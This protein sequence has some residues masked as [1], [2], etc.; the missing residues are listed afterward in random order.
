MKHLHFILKSLHLHYQF[1]NHF[2]I[3][4][5]GLS[6]QHLFY[7]ILI[8]ASISSYLPHIDIFVFNYNCPI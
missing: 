6:I 3:L 7:S 4:N 5:I 1:I 2:L 8:F